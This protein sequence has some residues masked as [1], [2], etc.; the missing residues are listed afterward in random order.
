M[1]RGRIAKPPHNAPQGEPEYLPEPP[2]K[3]VFGTHRMCSLCK[4]KGQ[5]GGKICG[6]CRGTGIETLS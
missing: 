4:G 5:K 3:L 2:K 6:V 1:S